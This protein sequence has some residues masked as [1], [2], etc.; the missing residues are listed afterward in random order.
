MTAQDSISFLQHTFLEK[1]FVKDAT[2]GYVVAEPFNL[3]IDPDVLRCA[4][5]CWADYFQTH[6]N[7]E[8]DAVVG[9][10]DAGSRLGFGLAS[11]LSVKA[12]LPAKR[13]D[14]IPGSWH[15][16]VSYINESF[17]TNKSD[18]KSHIGFVKPGMKVVLV[19]DVVAHGNTAVAA[20]KALQ[21]QGVEVVG[22]AVLFD[23]MWQKGAERITSETG[24]PVYSLI[25]LQEI[26]PK[27]EIILA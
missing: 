6:H 15:D 17:T 8:V 27:G 24:V 12:I 5:V 23:K 16:V 25:H 4:S 13:S 21:E 26:T 7:G 3:T 22:L 10:P 19:D 20:I 2:K 14:V 9:L 18:V 1:A 11:L